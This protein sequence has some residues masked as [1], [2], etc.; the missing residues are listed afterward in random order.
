MPERRVIFVHATRNALIPVVTI[1]AL[2]V[3]VLFGG[4]LI[5]E[6]IFSWLGMGSLIYEAIIGSDYYVAIVVL[7]LGVARDGQEPLG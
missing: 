7:D 2:S 3:P 1:L 5:T 6:T 4:A